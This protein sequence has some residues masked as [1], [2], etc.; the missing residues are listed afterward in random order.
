MVWTYIFLQDDNYGHSTN[1][2]TLNKSHPWPFHKREVFLHFFHVPPWEWQSVLNIQIHHHSASPLHVR[3]MA[4]PP[5]HTYIH[6]GPETLILFYTS[7]GH[8]ELPCVERRAE[9]IIRR[10]FERNPVIRADTE[11]LA[12]KPMLW[13]WEG[14]IYQTIETNSFYDC[15][16]SGLIG[17]NFK[18]YVC[19]SVA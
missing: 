15:P 7:T 16:K 13:L 1:H 3:P 14:S 10:R 4:F 18:G 9:R 17:G 12:V 6:N 19:P 11:I 8:N 5:V 2:R